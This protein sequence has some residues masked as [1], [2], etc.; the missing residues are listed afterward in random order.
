MDTRKASVVALT[1]C[2]LSD[3]AAV[4]LVVGSDVAAGVG[5]GVAV[6]GVLTLIA[7]F[8]VSRGARWSR[9]LALGTCVLD[10]LGVIPVAAGGAGVGATS[11]AAATVVLSSVAI[12]LV[13][14]SHEHVVGL[15]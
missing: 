10:I 3:V 13:L 6:I 1:L 8:G 15:A 12:A 14:R 11:A 5:V 2:A 9:P 4:P 7:A